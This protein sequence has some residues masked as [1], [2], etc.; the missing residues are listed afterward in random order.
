MLYL[1]KPHSCHLQWHVTEKCNFQCTHCYLNEDYIKQELSTEECYK[2]VDNFVDFCKKTD[3]KQNRNL[4]L[5][6]GEPILK[7]D[8]WKILEYISDYKKRGLIDRF[9]IM[10]NGSTVTDSIIKKYVE[11]GVNYMQI[12]IEGMEKINDEIRGKGNFQKAINGAKIIIQN[13]IPLSFSLTLTKKNT[14]DVE[15]LARL[16]ASIGVG[17]LGVGRIVP[18]GMGAQMKELMLTPKET[19]EWYLE[20]ERINERLRKDGLN[21]RVDYHCSDGMYQSIRPDANNPQTNHACST[22]FDVFTLLPNGDVVP[23]RRLPIVVGNFREKSF[24]EIHYSSNKIWNLK[25]WENRAEECKTCNSLRDCKGGGMCIAYGYFGTPY[26]PDPDCWKAFG[27]HLSTKKY[28]NPNSNKVTY[29]KRYINNLRFDLEPVSKEQIN[30]KIRRVKIDKLDKVKDNEVDILIFYFEEQDLNTETGAKILSFLKDLKKRGVKFEIG[31]TLPPCVSDTQ[32]LKDFRLK[33]PTNCY[34]CPSLFHL[35][36]NKRIVFCNDR[37]GPDLK[38]MNNRDQIWEY[39]ELL[40]DYDEPNFFKQC[41]TC[42]YRIRGTCYYLKNCR[43]KHRK[44]KEEIKTVKAT[45]CSC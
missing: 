22:P 44:L 27:E 29:F 19:R 4:T 35:E 9:Y 41:K 42:V 16:A 12:S 40:K 15:S 8:W 30:R 21:F 39:K 10:T 13:G 34:D 36:S 23:C 26:A 37:K 6:G 28:S 20:C 14:N 45:M 33:T 3:I 31:H 2:V 1:P 24:L 11:L 32:T 43:L 7:K 18:I 38:F 17:G 5:T 25:N